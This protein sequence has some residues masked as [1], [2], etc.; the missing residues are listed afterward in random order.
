LNK[1]EPISKSSALKALKP[2]LREDLLCLGR[3]LYNATLE[4]CEKYP[5]ILPRHRISEL[6]LDYAHAIL[7]EGTQLTLSNLK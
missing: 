7:H 6:L 2:M 3:R 5:I 4:Y 1:N